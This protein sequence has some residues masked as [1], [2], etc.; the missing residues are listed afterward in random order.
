MKMTNNCQ[1]DKHRRSINKQ[2]YV[3]KHTTVMIIGVNR[4]V[5]Q[6]ATLKYK[7]NKIK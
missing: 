1:N 6:S 5:L 2:F 3:L 7:S 4:E